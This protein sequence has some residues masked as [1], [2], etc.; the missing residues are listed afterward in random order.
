M[1][2]EPKL[3]LVFAVSVGGLPRRLAGGVRHVAI[4][5]GDGHGSTRLAASATATGRRKPGARELSWRAMRSPTAGAIGRLR[6]AI[7]APVEKGREQERPEHPKGQKHG[8]RI[9]SSPDV[10]QCQAED[11]SPGG[12]DERELD[13][14][15]PGRRALLCNR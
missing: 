8:R 14:Q 9:P 12:D 5:V 3:V 1:A 13:D 11:A 15:Q 7:V 6:A 4:G 2:A 10:C